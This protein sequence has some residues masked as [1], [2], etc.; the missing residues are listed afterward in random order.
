MKTSMNY[1]ISVS[2]NTRRQGASESMDH[3]DTAGKSTCGGILPFV[4]YISKHGGK[5][6]RGQ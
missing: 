1:E 2:A 5:A 6:P 4:S 3:Q